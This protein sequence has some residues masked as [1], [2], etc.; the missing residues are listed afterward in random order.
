MET[1]C[2]T[3]T[4]QNWLVFLQ[5]SIGNAWLNLD[6][7]IESCFFVGVDAYWKTWLQFLFYIWATAG[8]IIVD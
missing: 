6:F 2:D 3:V 1:Q 7:G 5:V 8:V 4:A